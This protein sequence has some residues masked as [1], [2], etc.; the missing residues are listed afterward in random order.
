MSMFGKILNK[1]GLKKEAAAEAPAKPQGKNFYTAAEAENKPEAAAKP[2]SK[3]ASRMID[4]QAMARR[5]DSLQGKLGA[6]ESEPMAMVD[7]MAKLEEMSRG[8]GLNWKQSIVDLLKVLD[9]DSSY[10]ARKA[11]AEELGCPPEMMTNSAAMNTW[12]HKTV[13]QKIAENGGNIPQELLN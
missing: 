6:A 9:M 8:S 5:T 11:L 12:L 3:P 7:V 10:E 1:L 13:L 4:R 2:A